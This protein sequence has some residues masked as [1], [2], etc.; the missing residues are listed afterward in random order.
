M[1]TKVFSFP[2]AVEAGYE[3]R[4]YEFMNLPLGY[5]NVVLDFKIWSK[6]SP[7]VTMFC[8]VI[9]TQQKIRF[10]VFRE[11]LT[12]KYYLN[13]TNIDVVEMA[14][15]TEFKVLILENSKGNTKVEGV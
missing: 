14:Y 9:E 4:D 12:K 10:N 7:A 13:K 3:P 5:Q 15:K 6:N 8:I 1:E 2:Q 11:R